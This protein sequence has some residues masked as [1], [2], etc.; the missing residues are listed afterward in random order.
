LKVF[1]DTNVWLSATVF[2]GLCEALLIESAQRNWLITSQLVRQ[3]AH[4]VLTR[5]FARL[6]RAPE[7]FDAVWS[8]ALCVPDV[9]KPMDDNDARL[10]N[11]ALQAGAVVFVTG[12]SRVL[13]WGKQGQM[14]TLNPRD[15]WM[16]L[17]ANKAVE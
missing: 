4:E 14:H 16:F 10:V 7:L 3:E 5:K 11:A 8:Q 1:L 12:D 13:S 17:F 2:A 15:A 9:D 6:P